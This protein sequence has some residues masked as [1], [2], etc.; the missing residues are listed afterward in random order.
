MADDWLLEILEHLLYFLKRVAQSW[1]RQPSSPY[2]LQ[3]A[4]RWK[5]SGQRIGI[6]ASMGVSALRGAESF[7][8]PSPP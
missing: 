3:V 7:D 6:I 1:H 8:E 5:E 4:N 2:H